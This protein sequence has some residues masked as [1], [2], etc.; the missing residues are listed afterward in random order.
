M[1][2]KGYKKARYS[3]VLVV[4]LLLIVYFSYHLL[5]GD[6]GLLSFI[7]L[8]ETI[9]R[10]QQELLRL[11]EQRVNLEE[12]IYRMKEDNLDL[13]LLEEIF[14]Y[15]TKSMAKTEFLIIIE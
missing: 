15:Q 8:S 6:R 5:H 13:D 14:R 10:E 11:R 2:L 7:S 1:Q 12:K 3:K 9:E 4:F